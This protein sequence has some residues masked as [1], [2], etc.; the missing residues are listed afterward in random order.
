MKSGIYNEKVAISLYEK[1]T[2]N[3]CQPAGLFIHSDHQYLA[4]SPDGLKGHNVLVEIKYPYSIR[5]TLYKE[6]IR[7][8]KLNYINHSGELKRQHNYYYQIYEACYKLPIDNGA[9]S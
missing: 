3:I 5:H 9:I 1:K 7:P 6:A 8:C 2:S 4:G